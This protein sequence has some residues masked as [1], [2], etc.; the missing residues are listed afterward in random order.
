MTR[1]TVLVLATIGSMLG[2]CASITRGTLNDV[3]F[4]S[5]PAGADI[6]LST[7]AVCR[8]PCL[9]QVE[10][11][12]SFIAMASMAG[13]QDQQQQV[14]TQLAGA[15]AAGFAGNLLIGGFIGMGVDAMTG[16]ANDHNPNPVHFIMVPTSPP[17]VA[18]PAP[19]RRALPVR[20]PIS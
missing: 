6:R 1:K 17:P 2:G 9:L 18:R 16:A 15:G 14:R 13:F 11:R 5:E 3:N 8:S 10:R 4:T 12:T 7:G 19:A 20:R